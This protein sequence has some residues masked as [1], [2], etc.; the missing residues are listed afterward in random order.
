MFVDRVKMQI[1]AGNGGNGAISFLHEKFVAKGGPAGGDGGKGGSIYFVAD[2]GLT[3][4]LDLQYRHK[5]VAGNGE[6]GQKKNMYGKSAEDVYVKVPVGTVVYDEASGR[7]V[8]DLKEKG[9]TLLIAKGGRGGRGNA[10]F[11]TSTN[12]I[13]RIAENG[14]QGEEFIAIIELKLLADVGLVGLPSVGKSTLL[15][16][17]SAA[18]PEIGDYPFT[19]LIPNLGMVS[20]KDKSQ[21]FVMADLPGL[22]EGAHEGKGLGLQFLRHV[23]RCKVLLHVVDMG[24]SEGRDPIE[25]FKVIN[26]ELKEYKLKLLEKPMIVAANKMDIDG[27][28]ENLKAFQKA[29]P[30]YEVYPITALAQEG[31][32]K[33]VYRLAEI[34]KESATVALTS[35]ADIEDKEFV[36]EYKKDDVGFKIEHPKSD[37]W[38]ITGERIEKLYHM[39]NIS[40]DQGFM[41]LLSTM[42]K[43]GVE[44]E[45]V[46]RGVKEGDTVRLCD[47]EFEYYE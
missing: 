45:L 40:E 7:I 35:S 29:Y 27:A 11:A 12:Q 41:Y 21:S 47:F 19:T 1:K 17:V 16:I 9:Q 44:D 2:S 3:T 24:A 13:P 4:L 37:L 32:D 10:K 6:N 8:A 15:S 28:E 20:T 36:Y 23:E 18:R 30:D 26:E 14:E 34:V 42:R 39:T 43:M 25:D 5:I 33:L 31:I 46:R 22:I 38:V